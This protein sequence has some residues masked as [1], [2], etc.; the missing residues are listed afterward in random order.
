MQIQMTT[1][2]AHLVY[3]EKP[4]KNR[5]DDPGGLFLPV[6]ADNQ[7]IFDGSQIK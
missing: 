7:G 6:K 1:T 5:P 2:L 4:K 3:S